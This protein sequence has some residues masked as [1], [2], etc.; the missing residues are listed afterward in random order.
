MS[1]WAHHRLA[2][3]EAWLVRPLDVQQGPR[4]SVSRCVEYLALLGGIDRRHRSV[5]WLQLRPLR[6]AWMLPLVLMGVVLGGTK[7]AAARVAD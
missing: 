4:P 7:K 2:A 3:L 5:G 6:D 1:D